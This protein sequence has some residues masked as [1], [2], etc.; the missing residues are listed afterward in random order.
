MA[1][2]STFATAAMNVTFPTW[3]YSAWGISGLCH[4]ADQVAPLAGAAA[5]G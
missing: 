3:F 4:A 2:Y 5:A 1:R